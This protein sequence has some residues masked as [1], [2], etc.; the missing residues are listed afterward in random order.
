[1][2]RK[3]WN[4]GEATAGLGQG[5]YFT[6]MEGSLRTPALVRY[7]GHVPAGKVSNEIVHITD[8]FTTLIRWAG[9]EVPND[10]V[11]DGVGPTRIL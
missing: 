6:G 7:P 11:I 1:M 10:R 4:R 8:M 3:R 5:S 9:L 2:A